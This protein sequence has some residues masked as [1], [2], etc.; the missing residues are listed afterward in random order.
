MNTSDQ[1]ENL[2]VP[3]EAEFGYAQAIR[4][5]DTVYL[6]GQVAH[7]GPN[8]VAPAPI[9]A[10]GVVTDFTHLAAQMR[11]CYANATTLLRRFGASLDDV[12]EEVIF[13]IDIDAAYAAAG[14][15]RSEAYAQAR[16]VVTSTLIGVRRLAFP[17]LLVE[18]KLTARI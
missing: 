1:V 17:E 2:D 13:A 18:V 9:D 3:W 15:V 4:R 5:G 16:P 12:V 11:Q 7:D 8:L 6:S 14:P 10:T